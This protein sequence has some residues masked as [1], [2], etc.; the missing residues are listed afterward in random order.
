MYKLLFFT[1]LFFI[2]CKSSIEPFEISGKFA[3]NR[4]IS[5]QTPFFLSLDKDSTFL[6][7]LSY[8]LKCVGKWTFIGSNSIF[9]KCNEPESPFAPMTFG[10]M[11]ERGHYIKIININKVEINSFNEKKSV[12]LKR[13]K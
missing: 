8:P 2:S 10:Y 6:L 9:L 11:D 7:R 5:N 3:K 1:L 4:K 13:R 12:I